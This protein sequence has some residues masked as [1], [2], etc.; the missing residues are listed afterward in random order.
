MKIVSKIVLGKLTKEEQHMLV[1]LLRKLDHFH[2]NIFMNEKHLELE[3]II[4]KIDA[5]K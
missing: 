1:Y 5:E 3:D 2:N 4:T